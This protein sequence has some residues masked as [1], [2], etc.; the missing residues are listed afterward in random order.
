MNLKLVIFNYPLCERG[1]VAHLS[2][3]VYRIIGDKSPSHF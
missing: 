2:K 3:D 1:F